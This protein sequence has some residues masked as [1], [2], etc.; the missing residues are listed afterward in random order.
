MNEKQTC[1]TCGSMNISRTEKA[2][3]D[4]ATHMRMRAYKCK[5]CHY[6]WIKIAHMEKNSEEASKD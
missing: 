5:D 3:R 1:P 4:K 6:S 2:K